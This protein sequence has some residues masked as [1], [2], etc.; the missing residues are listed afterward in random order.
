M[1]GAPLHFLQSVPHIF[2]HF[3]FSKIADTTN[4]QIMYHSTPYEL[5]YPIPKFAIAMETV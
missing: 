4:D 1:G 2:C 5:L 3:P